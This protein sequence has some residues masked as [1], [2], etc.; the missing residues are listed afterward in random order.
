MIFR[1]T[2]MLAKKIGMGTLPDFPGGM[3]NPLADWCA[4]VFRVEHRQYILLTNSATLYSV[5][6]PGKGITSGRQ[7]T[8]NALSCLRE[9]MVLDG[10]GAAFAR[11]VEENDR[12]VFFTKMADRRIMGSMN[13]FVFQAKAYLEYCEKSPLE[14]SLLLN[15]SVKLLL[16]YGRPMDKFR[17]LFIQDGESPFPLEA[18]GKGNVIYL[19]AVRSSAKKT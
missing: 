7:F 13:D 1:L 6:M 12:N 3:N 10:T 4:H 11:L 5:I 17:E 2:S 8:K 18:E 14:A 19:D 15:E 9:F 16:D